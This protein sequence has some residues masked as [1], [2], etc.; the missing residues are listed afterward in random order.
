[1]F[2]TVVP[3]RHTV[4][5]ADKST[6]F[7]SNYYQTASPLEREEAKLMKSLFSSSEC[8]NGSLYDSFK[9]AGA[10]GSLYY[11]IGDLIDNTIIFQ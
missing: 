9:I 8:I 4:R 7:L 10:T 2:I 6:K 5:G 3:K 11:W 1:M